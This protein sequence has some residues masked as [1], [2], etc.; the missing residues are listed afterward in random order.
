[1]NRFSKFKL[2]EREE[3]GIVL[4]GNDVELRRADCERSLVEKVWG[5]KRVN[6]TGLKNTLSQLWS[7]RGELRV[8]ELGHNFF[9]FIFSNQEDRARVLQRRP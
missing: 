6:F 9:H 7:Q 2:V 1:M 5:N 3:E 4:E 8:M